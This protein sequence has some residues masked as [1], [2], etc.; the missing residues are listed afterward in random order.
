VEA[1]VKPSSVGSWQTAVVKEQAGDLVYGIYANTSSNRPEAQVYVNGAVRAV[2]GTAQVPAGS[3]THLAATYDGTTLRL[4]VNGTQAGQLAVSGSI[5][6]STQPVRIGGNNIWGERFNGLIDEVR[7]YN[8][9]L[10]A[11]QIQNDMV[12]SITPDVT[13]PT[14]TA[15]TPASGAAGINVG[16]SPTVTFNEAMDPTSITSST[17]QL[18]NGANSVATNVTYDAATNKATITPQAALTYGATYTVTVK[19]G[20][21]GVTDLAGNPLA[22]DSSWSFSTE[23][24]PPQILV[25]TSTSNLFGGYLAEILR[26]EGVDAF[27]TIDASFLS[28]S[29]LSGFD[30]VLLGD[31]TLNSSQVTTLTN[32]VNGGGNLIAMHPDKQLAGLLGL[33]DAGS[34]LANA[35]L[36]IDTTQAPGAGIVS[37]TIQYHGTADRYT[38]NGATAVATLYSNA[39]TATSNP[40]V[41]L[42]S[43][44]SN[45]GQAAAFT[46]DLARSIVYTREGNPAWAGQDRDGFGGFRPNDLFYG[47]K[48]GD[49]QPDWLDTSKIAIP[50]ADEQQRLLV[51]M[52][53]MME[54]DKL[55]LPHFWYLPRGLKA[56][57]AMSGDDHSPTY[58]PGGTASN[59]AW[60]EQQSAPGCVVALWQCIRTTSYL[61]TTATITNAQAASYLADGFE[62]ALHPL[63]GACPPTAPTEADLTTAFD[64]QL[65][66]WQARYP[67]IPPPVTTRTHCV[68]WSS[69]Y[70]GEAKVE[71]AHGMRMDGN[72]YHY[73]AS[74]LGSKPGFLTGGGFPQRFADQNGQM[75]DIYQENTNMTD[76]SGQSY[77]ATVN[78]L[79]DNAL[80]PLGYYGAFGTNIHTDEP[81][82]L[83]DDEAIVASAQARN[84]PIINYKQL[85]DWTDGRNASTIRSMSWNNGTFTFTTTVGSG[86]TGLQTMLPTAGPSGTLSALSCGGSPKTYTVLTIKGVQYAMFDAVTGT[87]QATYS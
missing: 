7:I 26:G 20:A 75:I 60:F 19:G 58:A 63:L 15:K 39:S 21:G 10:T 13:P 6:T 77:P 61:I 69:T 71:A 4:Y 42:R 55:P 59:F 12:R 16:T 51:N 72:Y 54:R 53:T 82:P 45:G 70:V 34:T 43:V 11:A 85:L 22:A 73:P 78:T 50:Q 65:A 79:L 62:I 48:S 33:T 3:W 38:L 49:V 84:V 67:S 23:S 30:V 8:R 56:V 87:C 66:Q 18:K 9:A 47:A 68:A 40:A 86:A 24:S 44:G 31:M 76:E 83:P 5:L 41:T 36:K 64:Q 28:P 80:G 35:Y 52:M 1:W 46:F 81:A 2:D 25:V 74:W 17:I 32:W 29:L 57:V 27:T 14:V 37:Q